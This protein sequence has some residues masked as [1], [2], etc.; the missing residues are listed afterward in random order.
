MVIHEHISKGAHPSKL[1]KSIE[2]L[3]FTAQSKFSFVR[4]ILE[5]DP[6][7]IDMLKPIKDV[8][9]N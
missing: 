2:F 6:I 3:I 7:L 8:L 1:Q 4:P 5:R 9:L